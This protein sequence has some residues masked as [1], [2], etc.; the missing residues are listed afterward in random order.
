VLVTLSI[1][2]QSKLDSASAD[3]WIHRARF[4]EPDSSTLA[5]ALTRRFIDPS[6]GTDLSIHRA[7]P[8]RRPNPSIRLQSSGSS[9]CIA[10]H[11][12]S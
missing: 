5:S 2:P 12:H 11:A 1:R 10:T 3:P 4:I 6:L 8:L 9:A 7:W